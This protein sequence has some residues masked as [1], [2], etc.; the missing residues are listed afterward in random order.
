MFL[1]IPNVVEKAGKPYFMMRIPTDLV[2]RFGMKYIRKSLK[3]TDPD[4]A[5]L[6]AASMTSKAKSLFTILRSGSLPTEQE[7]TLIAE[8]TFHPKGKPQGKPAHNRHGKLQLQRYQLHVQQGCHHRQPVII[9]HNQPR[10]HRHRFHQQHPVRAN[11]LQL[12][13]T[14]RDLFDNPDLWYHAD[15]GRNARR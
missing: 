5:R 9:T 1:D 8:Y 4:G 3:T 7:N 2:E 14:G 6:L 11:C 12:S 15:H 10:R 13:S